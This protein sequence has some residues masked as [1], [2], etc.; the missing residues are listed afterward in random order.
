MAFKYVFNNHKILM[1]SPVEL[2][3]LRER[4]SKTYTEISKE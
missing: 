3:P 4:L 1:P 2:V